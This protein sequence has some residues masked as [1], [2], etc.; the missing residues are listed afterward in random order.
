MT[1][2]LIKRPDGSALFYEVVQLTAD[3]HFEGSARLGPRDVVDG[4]AIGDWPIGIHTVN[5]VE[6]RWDPN[7]PEAENGEA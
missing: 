5:G 7:A 2:V 6:S 4:V 3:H 1:K